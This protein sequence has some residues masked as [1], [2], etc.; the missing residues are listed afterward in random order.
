MAIC[1]SNRQLIEFCYHYTH[2]FT[3]DGGSYRH[4]IRV[5][6]EPASMWTSGPLNLVHSG[7][8]VI[9][10][11]PTDPSPSYF[12]FPCIALSY[13]FP[14][15]SGTPLSIVFLESMSGKYNFEILHS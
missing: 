5:I 1:Y 3:L 12:L 15:F 11:N 8:P 4:K 2:F 10:Q 7:Q 13:L 6:C 14:S 9:L